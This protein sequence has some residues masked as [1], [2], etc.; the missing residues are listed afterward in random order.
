MAVRLFRLIQS[1]AVAL[2]PRVRFKFGAILARADS[3]SGSDSLAAEQPPQRQRFLETCR[4][5]PHLANRRFRHACCFL[6]DR[7]M[8]AAIARA[9]SRRGTDRGMQKL[10]KQSLRRAKPSQP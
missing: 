7:L 4:A 3:H 1:D 5:M 9:A 6:H 10:L 8:S 2:D